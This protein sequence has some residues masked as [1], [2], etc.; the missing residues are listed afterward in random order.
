MHLLREMRLDKRLTQDEVAQV[1]GMTREDYNTLEQGTGGRAVEKALEKLVRIPPRWDRPP[2]DRSE[3]M[4]TLN[5][6]SI[7]K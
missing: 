3:C 4:G 7:Q 2:E 1:L 5:G 6:K